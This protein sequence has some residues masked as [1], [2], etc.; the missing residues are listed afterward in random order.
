MLMLHIGYVHRGRVIMYLCYI[1]YY[2]QS[3]KC[4]TQLLL[5]CYCIQFRS[6]GGS[7]TQYCRTPNMVIYLFD[8]YDAICYLLTCNECYCIHNT[9]DLPINIIL[10]VKTGIT[11]KFV[12]SLSIFNLYTYEEFSHHGP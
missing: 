4:K 10:F 12:T 7:I 6:S 5:K 3:L 8:Q 11:C 2:E 9:Y 1:V